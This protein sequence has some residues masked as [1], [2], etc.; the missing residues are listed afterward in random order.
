MVKIILLNVL[1]NENK[2]KRIKRYL[3][4]ESEKLVLENV[5]PYVICE[6]L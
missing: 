6:S 5:L 3:Q 2:K 4:L 1:K